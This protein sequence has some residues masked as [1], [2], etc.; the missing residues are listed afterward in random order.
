[1]PSKLGTLLYAAFPVWIRI[2]KPMVGV[3]DGVSLSHLTLGLT[4]D[5]QERLA[6]YLLSTRAAEESTSTTALVVPD[7]DP[8]LAH[9]AG[10]IVVTQRDAAADG[11]ARPRSVRLR[12]RR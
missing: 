1:M 12:K 6:R 9:L 11:S 5:V 4:Y 2:V 7:D 10:G 8:Y 3:V